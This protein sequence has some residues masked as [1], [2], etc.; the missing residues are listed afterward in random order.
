M[1]GH[2]PLHHFSILRDQP[3]QNR[4]VGLIL[5]RLHRIQPRQIGK[6]DAQLGLQPIQPAAILDPLPQGRK[7]P[8]RIAC[9]GL[10]IMVLAFR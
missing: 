4:L 7:R 2:Q 1:I 10:F 8:G 5:E 3:A 6:A 9:W